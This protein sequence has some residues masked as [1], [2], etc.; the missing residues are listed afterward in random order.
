[1]LVPKYHNYVQ[2]LYDQEDKV[3]HANFVKEN[4]HSMWIIDSKLF[5]FITYLYIYRLYI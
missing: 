1:M 2:G 3:V 5:W 4:G